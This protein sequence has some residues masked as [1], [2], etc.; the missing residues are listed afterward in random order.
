MRINLETLKL[1]DLET[2]LLLRQFVSGKKEA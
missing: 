1:C 2:S